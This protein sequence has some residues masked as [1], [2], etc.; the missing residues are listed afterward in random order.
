[1]VS[2]RQNAISANLSG[3]VGPWLSDKR[4]YWTNVCSYLSSLLNVNSVMFNS[5]SITY[6]MNKQ[7]I[8]NK[9]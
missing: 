7:K 5:M 6:K 3:G 4:T 9:I 2:D 1:M 8:I